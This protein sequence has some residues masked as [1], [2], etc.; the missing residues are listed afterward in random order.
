[1]GS[2]DSDSEDGDD[3][4]SYTETNV[5]L[6]YAAVEPSDDTISYLGGTP[7]LPLTNFFTVYWLKIIYRHG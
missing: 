6:G 1:M 4:T 2:Y 7:V 5:L 3:A